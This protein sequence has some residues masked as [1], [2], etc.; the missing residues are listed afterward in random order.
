MARTILTRCMAV[1]ALLFVYGA[2]LIG[3]TVLM[4]TAST[5]AQARR[6][7][8][9]RGVYFG[10][11]YPA[12]GYGYPAYGYGYSPYYYAAPGPRCYWSRRWR[13]TICRY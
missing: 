4:T 2:Y 7:R 8:G 9:R 3:A 10:G 13:R 12:Y 1:V 11:G 5:Q 6:W